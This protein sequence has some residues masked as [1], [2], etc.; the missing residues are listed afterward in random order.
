MIIEDAAELRNFVLP[1]LV[2]FSQ[3]Q[4]QHAL[5]VLEAVMVSELRHKTLACCC[6]MRITLRWQTSSGA[7]RGVPM[8]SG[9]R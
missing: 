1:L 9:G 3:A 2:M 8:Q 4:Q 7:V 6:R 5:N